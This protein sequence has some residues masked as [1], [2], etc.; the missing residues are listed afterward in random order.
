MAGLTETQSHLKELTNG[1]RD[2]EAMP[3]SIR[4]TARNKADI[5]RE[6]PGVARDVAR[7]AIAQPVSR[8][9]HLG[10]LHRRVLLLHAFFSHSPAGA[11]VCC[12]LMIPRDGLKDNVRARRH[13]VRFAQMGVLPHVRGNV[14]GFLVHALLE[15]ALN[16]RLRTVIEFDIVRQGRDVF[17]GRQRPK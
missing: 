1:L 15:N 6:G 9:R 7:A 13:Q 10:N 14:R 4:C 17:S 5:M 16:N 11:S 8:M 12:D 3:R 2:A